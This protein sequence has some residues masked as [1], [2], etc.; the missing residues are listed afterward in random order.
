MESLWSHY[1]YNCVNSLLQMISKG[2]LTSLDAILTARE[3]KA[4]QQLYLKI[5]LEGCCPY[6]GY[7]SMKLYLVKFSFA[8]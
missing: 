4:W 7:D 2:E 8:K 3:L 6:K 5:E 1:S